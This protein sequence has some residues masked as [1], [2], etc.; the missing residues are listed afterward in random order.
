MAE[1]ASIWQAELRHGPAATLA[2]GLE[3]DV[4]VVGGGITG[5][6]AALLLASAGRSVALL[7][8]DRIGGGTTGSTSAHVTAV[9]DIGYRRLLRC[10]S[11]AA[12]K[13][14]VL[15]CNSALELMQ[16]FVDSERIACDWQR[17]PAYWFSEDDAGMARLEGEAHVAE[18]LGQECRLVRDVPLPWTTAG[19]LAV[20]RQALF[21]PLRYVQ[22]LARV[23]RQRGAQIFES[24]PV[25]AWEET[26]GGVTVDTA[27]ARVRAASLLLATHTPL[28]LNAVQTEL[29]AMQSYVLALTGAAALPPALFWDTADPYHYIRPY[30][31]GARAVVLVGGADHK[32]GHEPQTQDHFAALASYARHRLQSAT[33]ATW[34][35]AQF[36]DPADGLPYIGRS[37]LSERVY[38]ATGFAGVGLVQGT[39]A[40]MDLA[41]RLRGTEADVPWKATR[42]TLASTPRVVAEGFDVAT[43]WI[44]DR[45][46]PTD[47]GSVDDLAAGQGR[48]LRIDGQRRAVYRDDNGRLHILSPVCTHL[49]CLVH[50]NHS[51]RTWDCPCHGTRY[52]ATGEVLEGPAL[53]PL[54]HLETP[55]SAAPPPPRSADPDVQ[56]FDT[57]KG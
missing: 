53:S 28:G 4:A 18:R 22:G 1:C 45:L 21:H 42:L 7:E 13:E 55:P 5:V 8:A 41:D 52:A 33:I 24:T 20:P 37:P 30:Q 25:V 11:E 12:A 29:T 15:R 57:D 10:C 27:T 36:Y 14:Y 47:G 17:V 26:R 31:D 54:A 48:M 49:G 3:V 9:P 35:S 38:I 56:R 16:S 51:A 40:A 50:W 32:T 6:T 2:D 44:G 19:G 46:L 43:H 39:M 23:A 34:W